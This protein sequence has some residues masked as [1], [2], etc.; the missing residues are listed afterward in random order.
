MALQSE[1]VTW[2][3]DMFCVVPGTTIRKMF[4]G[5]GVFRHGLMYALAT[6]DGRVSMKADE[7]TIPDFKAEGCEEWQ[8]VRKSGKSATMG[9]WYV[10]ERL[11]DDSDALL[12]WSMKA[13]DVALRADQKK[14]PSQRKMRD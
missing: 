6:S 10:P 13:F 4:G 5:V 11:S 7:Q 9:Y 12:E 8:Y 2:L 3:E 1:F 14:S